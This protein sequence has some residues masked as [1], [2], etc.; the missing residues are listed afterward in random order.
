M[1]FNVT[2]VK[3]PE[4]HF[5]KKTKNVNAQRLL[6]NATV[7]DGKICC[8]PNSATLEG[9]KECVGISIL[10]KEKKFIANSMPGFDLPQLIGVQLYNKIKILRESLKN[11]CDE[12]VA[13]IIGGVQAGETEMSRDSAALVNAYYDEL[14]K[15]N[16]P[17]T[18]IAQQKGPT[19][20]EINTYFSWY[21]AFLTGEPINKLETVEKSDLEKAEEILSDAFDFVE[22]SKYFPV[23]IVEKTT[24][25]LK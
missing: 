19:P 17:I 20:S 1:N 6:Q 11:R 16:I 9:L 18:V 21:S 12:M 13:L 2:F 14:R 15:Y 7:R 25:N 4:F 22:I 10:T 8:M 24:P 23:S 3:N 5:A